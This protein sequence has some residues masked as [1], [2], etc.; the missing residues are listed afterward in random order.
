MGI[1]NHVP[2]HIRGRGWGWT[3]TSARACS[4]VLPVDGSI[5]LLNEKARL[6]FYTFQI[7]LFTSFAFFLCLWNKFLNCLTVAV[8]P[9]LPLNIPVI[10]IQMLILRRLK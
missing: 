2:I 4:P 9:V 1:V 5:M 10:D 3:S 6:I 7:V 8:L